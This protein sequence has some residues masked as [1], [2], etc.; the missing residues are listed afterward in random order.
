MDMFLNESKEIEGGTRA[1]LL[2]RALLDV[3]PGTRHSGSITG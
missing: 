2:V 1:R 3:V